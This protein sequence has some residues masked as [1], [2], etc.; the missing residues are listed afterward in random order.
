MVIFLIVLPLVEPPAAHSLLVSFIWLKWR[1]DAEAYRARWNYGARCRVLCC[2]CRIFPSLQNCFLGGRAQIDALSKCRSLAF[3]RG[4]LRRRRTVVLTVKT[5]FE[6]L[7]TRSLSQPLFWETLKGMDF[8]RVTYYL[9]LSPLLP[10][11]PITIKG[12]FTLLWPLVLCRC[13]HAS[14]LLRIGWCVTSFAA[15]YSRERGPS[16]N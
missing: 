2:S 14:C 9:Y 12:A 16:L 8:T 3:L 4:C 10:P 13:P 5:N 7:H 11:H 15:M 1:T 6:L